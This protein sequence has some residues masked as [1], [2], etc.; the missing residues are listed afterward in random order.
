MRVIGPEFRLHCI[1]ATYLT[2]CLKPPAWWTSLE[3]GVKLPPATARR[4]QRVGVRAG[5]PDIL[6][7]NEGLAYW[8]E[9]KAPKTGRLSEAQILTR[10]RLWDAGACWA[11]ARSLDELRA[12]L[13]AWGIP[14]RETKMVA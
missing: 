5:I 9:L 13:I 2:A 14:L 4:L 11:M 3:H 1:C 10:D 12:R 8:I 7:I 6:I